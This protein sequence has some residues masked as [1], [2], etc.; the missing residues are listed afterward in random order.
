MG[1]GYRMAMQEIMIFK[2]LPH[3]FLKTLRF[4]GLCL[5]IWAAFKK[6]INVD[7]GICKKKSSFFLYASFCK[8][9]LKMTI[10]IQIIS[11]E[12]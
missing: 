12:H 7:G 5:H 9:I 4:D 1:S 2:T 10:L 8:F 11:D 3:I 6:A